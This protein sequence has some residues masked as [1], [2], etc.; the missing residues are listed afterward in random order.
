MA[1]ANWIPAYVLVLGVIPL[2]S[3]SIMLLSV[4]Q[5]RKAKTRASAVHKAQ[6]GLFETIWF[7]WRKAE[8]EVADVE[9]GELP[10]AEEASGSHRERQRGGRGEE[11]TA[12]EWP[13]AESRD[14]SSCGPLSSHPTWP[15]NGREQQQHTSWWRGYGEP[16]GPVNEDGVS[17]TESDYTCAPGGGNTDAARYWGQ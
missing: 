16:R 1:E 7:P 6:G 15:R 9:L 3:V 11:T 10:P 8:K 5:T 4:R 14:G 17:V 13:V 12:R 2:I